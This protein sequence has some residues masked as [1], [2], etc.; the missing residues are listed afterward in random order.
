ML[1][2]PRCQRFFFVAKLRLGAAI[3]ILAREVFFSLSPGSLSRLAIAASLQK[4]NPLAP[5][6]LMLD[7][8]YI[9]ILII[10]DQTYLLRQLPSF[11]TESQIT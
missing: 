3:E 6:A 2:Y 11:W 4:E 7:G 8:M 9:Q 1:G 10:T 5:K